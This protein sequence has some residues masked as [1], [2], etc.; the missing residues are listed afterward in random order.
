MLVCLLNSV[1]PV[2]PAWFPL[3]NATIPR[4]PWG[5]NWSSHRSRL[6]SRPSAITLCAPIVR[7]LRVTSRILCS[8]LVVCGKS[9]LW[10]DVQLLLAPTT[11]TRYSV[12]ARSWSYVCF[13]GE[14]L[15][16]QALG[17]GRCVFF[18]A[19]VPCV[20]GLH[21][22]PQNLFLFVVPLMDGFQN[23]LL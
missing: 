11:S 2:S 7:Q 18:S 8:F 21:N 4:R 20:E 12:M 22:F 19:A 16:S 5:A 1:R 23:L 13:D 3:P 9:S 17:V 14:L 10:G 15:G 6:V